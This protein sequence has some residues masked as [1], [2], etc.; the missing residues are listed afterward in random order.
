MTLQSV[1]HGHVVGVTRDLEHSY[2]MSLNL[3]AF[4][5]RLNKVM[6]DEKNPSWVDT[7]QKETTITK[8][9]YSYVSFRA[10]TY[11]QAI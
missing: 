1:D 3:S 2:T 9:L 11:L 6:R 5:G 10:E 7:E 4:E 8:T